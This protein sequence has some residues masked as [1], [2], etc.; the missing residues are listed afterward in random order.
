LSFCV[1]NGNNSLETQK[2]QFGIIW[3]LVNVSTQSWMWDIFKDMQ[4]WK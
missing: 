2:S 1:T 3:E 4:N